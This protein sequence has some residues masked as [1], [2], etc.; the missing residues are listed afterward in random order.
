MKIKTDSQAV[1]QKITRIKA[2]SSLW[3]V[4]KLANNTIL[5]IIKHLIIAK[6]L[7]VDFNKIKGHSGDSGNDKADELAK[8]ALAHMLDNSLGIIRLDSELGCNMNYGI[9]WK[10][11]LVEGNLWKFNRL[12]SNGL[13]DSNWSLGSI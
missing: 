4:Y 10:G 11:H 12:V 6:N 9:N 1:I 3:H 7:E 13:A 2:I 5:S 8:E